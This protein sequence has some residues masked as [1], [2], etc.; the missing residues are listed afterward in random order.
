MDPVLP[1]PMYPKPR[2]L[3]ALIRSLPT[4]YS[5]RVFSAASTSGFRDLSLGFT[6]TTVS[7]RSLAMTCTSPSWS[8]IVTEI[9]SRVSS[10]LLDAE[11]EGIGQ[12]EVEP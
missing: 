6:T 12:A 8:S 11:L 7:A 4:E 9:G 1:R 10:R 3:G 2:G 5:T